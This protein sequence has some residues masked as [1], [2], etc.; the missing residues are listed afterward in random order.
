MAA[1]AQPSNRALNGENKNSQTLAPTNKQ[2]NR[3]CWWRPH[4]LLCW[5]VM[6]AEQP[7]DSPA[8]C[9]VYQCFAGVTDTH[10]CA[11]SFDLYINTA[12]A[13][14]T[15]NC[16]ELSF[17]CL[18]KPSFVHTMVL[19]FTKLYNNVPTPKKMNS[20]IFNSCISVLFSI[21]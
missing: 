4:V 12:W 2:T 5:C 10:P 18:H 16:K 15:R 1:D 14:T 13:V 20:F 7:T 6:L 11:P 3:G 19:H 21:I 17:K 9:W 8:I